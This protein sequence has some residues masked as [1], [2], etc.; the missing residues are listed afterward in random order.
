MVFL[1]V[2]FF[3]IIIGMFLEQNYIERRMY[4]NLLL[5]IYCGILFIGNRIEAEDILYIGNRIINS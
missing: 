1:I 3:F 2:L 4:F 5:P